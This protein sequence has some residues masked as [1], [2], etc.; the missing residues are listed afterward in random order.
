MR[1]KVG[2]IFADPVLFPPV[3][4][5][6]LQIVAATLAARG[7]DVKICCPFL[8]DDFV[9]A[10]DSF[11]RDFSPLLVGVSLRN[12]DVAC[13]DSRG[14]NRTFLPELR[15]I[16]AR[17]AA[18]NI[19]CVLGGSGF[20]IEPIAILMATG[21]KLG[22]VGP[23]ES[24]FA[25]YCHRVLVLK[26]DPLEAARDLE[27]AVTQDSVYSLSMLS[28]GPLGSAT[29]HHAASIEYARLAGGSVPIRTKTGCSLRCTY[30]AIP[31]IEP[32]LMRSWDEIAS[33][34]RLALNAGLGDRIFFADSEFN[35][36]SI[37]RALQLCE[38]IHAEFGTR[39]RWRC[40]LEAGFVTEQLVDAMLAAG[41]V[42]VS[43]TVDSLSDLPRIGL[44]KRTPALKARR[45]LEL[46]L[47]REVTTFVTL[48]FG[49][50]GETFATVDETLQHLRPAV[51]CG[52]QLAIG[53]GLRIYDGTPLARIATNPRFSSFVY[54]SSDGNSAA[55]FSS[56]VAAT[57]LQRYIEERV[58][59][60]RHVT[61]EWRD[62]TDGTFYR[63]L[64]MISTLLAAGDH[65][66]AQERAENMLLQP[67][68]SL[69]EIELALLKCERLRIEESGH[70]V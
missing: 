50:P 55:V 25:E 17:I 18:A 58:R 62:K 44:A 11:V 47:S 21:V 4:P 34:L 2:L 8:T 3:Q 46:L 10:A 42:A 27:G 41:C 53:A 28:R 45:A 22:F 15:Q 60:W 24:S 66:G 54:R 1:P 5:Y 56:P 14:T 30:C 59:D 36:P 69:K 33:E 37:E 51:E 68:H 13:I 9:A 61:L 32:L 16:T 63:Q 48:L 23:S 20:A 64:A 6:G 35:L 57:E 52:A 65:V 7:L 26:A 43:L 38:L 49:G 12:Y 31:A 67:Y 39:I 29:G 40:Y 19:P 70:N